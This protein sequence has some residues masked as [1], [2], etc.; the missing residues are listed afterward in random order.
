MFGVGGGG[1]ISVFEADL[2][3]GSLT[4]VSRTGPELENLNT[5]YLCISPNGQ[6]LYSTNEVG[7]LDGE[8]GGGGGVL[9]F[10]ID[11]DTGSLAW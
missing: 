1:G 9:S 6:F 8:F 11:P 3:D 10:S 5:D 2:S 4:S 7:N